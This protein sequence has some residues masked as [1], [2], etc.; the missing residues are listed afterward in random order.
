M[1]KKILKFLKRPFVKN[2]IILSSGTAAAQ[3]I[4]LL[5][6]PIITRLYGPYA[7]GLM[8][9]FAAVISIIG[10]I[11]SL[12]FPIAIVLPKREKE[13]IGIMKLSLLTT[14]F[15][16]LISILV[17]IILNNH[18]IKYFDLEGIASFLYL[19]PIAM[20]LSGILQITEQWL[21]RTK[22]FNISAK[23][24]FLQAVIVN[25]GKAGVGF[26]Y[27]VASVLII[28]TALRQGLKALLLIL[29]T[30]D[31]KDL[32]ILLFREKV[33]YRKLIW[34]YRDFPLYRAPE[35][36]INAISTNLPTVLLTI[37][38]GPA[39]AGFYSI[40]KTVLNIPSQ[41]IGKS[42]GDV[43]YPRITEAAN[44][45]ENLTPLILKATLI[46]GAI[47]FI[48]FGI[49][50]L[51]GPVLFSFVFGEEWLIAGEYARWIALWSYFSFMN[52]PSVRALPVLSAQ[53]FHLIYTIF[54]LITRVIVIA[55]GFF[56]FSSDIVAVTLFGTASAFLNIGL[57]LMTLYISV[58]FDRLHKR[59]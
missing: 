8:G 9:T 20:F 33:S 45:N 16:S 4:A 38:F 48:P 49:V 50:V 52:R 10:P 22:Q 32:L 17:L 47:G 51:F 5:L 57:I 19:I 40:G 53:A 58:R 41:L 12:T 15:I 1:K 3:L 2:V 25:G 55:I 59:I 37:F 13:A 14:I 35:I 42:V 46:L 36:C 31:I 54:M 56:V 44:S 28:F 39:S 23:I 29:F 27:P 21:I 43:F 24:T 26:L 18:I 30:R 6:T 7:Y 34:K 11:A